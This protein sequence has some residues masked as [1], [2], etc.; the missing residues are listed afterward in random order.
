MKF[1]RI[2]KEKTQEKNLLNCNCICLGGIC[3]TQICKKSK[4]EWYA[5]PSGKVLAEN[6]DPI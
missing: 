4:E 1:F 2:R 3:V 6:M 5:I